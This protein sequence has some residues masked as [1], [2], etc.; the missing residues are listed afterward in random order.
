MTCGICGSTK[1]IDLRHGKPPVNLRCVDCGA[2]FWE[3]WHSKK[4]WA[5]ALAED[6][7]EI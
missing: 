6:E 4:E 7:Y 2:R 3:R 1:V 5:E